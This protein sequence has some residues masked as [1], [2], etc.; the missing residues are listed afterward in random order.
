MVLCQICGNSIE[1]S[2][3]RCPYC[4]SEQEKEK[5]SLPTKPR[6][7]Q[8]TVN[9][10][11]GLPTVEQALRRLK[12]ELES[13]AQEQIRIL[14]LIHGYGSTGKGGAIRLECRKTLSFLASNGTIHS[15]Y[16][17]EEFNRRQGHIKHLLGRFPDLNQHPHLNRNNK[18]ITLVQLF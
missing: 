14:T 17:G 11:Q 3:L 7:S 18:G 12:A 8:K 9:L 5:D 4:L 2:A 15:F 13:A 16:P 6:F 10:E 1:A